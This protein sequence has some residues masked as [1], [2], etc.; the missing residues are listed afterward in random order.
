MFENILYG[1]FYE[2]NIV[3]FRQSNHR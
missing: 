3:L 1:I 2:K